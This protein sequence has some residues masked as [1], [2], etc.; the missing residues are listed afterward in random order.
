MRVLAAH[1]NDAA[2]S[3]ISAERLL[4]REPA[5]A[6][7]DDAAITTGSDAAKQAR[8]KPRRI[9]NRFW[10][11]LS[12]EPL[13]VSRYPNYSNADL[14]A[15]HLE[16]IW[17]R[18][19]SEGDQLV[20]AVPPSMDNTQLALFL[21]V[22]AEI[23]I[24]VAGLFD[25][26]VAATRREYRGAVPVH[27]DVSLHRVSVSRLGQSSQVVAERSEILDASGLVQLSDAWIRK[28]S[29]CFV[30][31]SRFDPLHTAETEQMLA[32]ALPDWLASASRSDSISMTVDYHGID[33]SAEIESLDLVSAAAPVY[34]R[35]AAQLRALLRA[36]EVPA[37][38]LSDRAARLPGLAELLT[39]R[40]GGEV[41]LLE[42]GAT[43]RGLLQRAK[44]SAGNGG[45]VSL[46]RALPW[47]QAAVDVEASAEEGSGERPTHILFGSVA[48]PITA[49]PLVLGS[50]ADGDDRTV[51]FGREMPGLSRRHCS[52][53]TNGGQCVVEDHSRY[54]TFLN[55][56]KIDGSVVLQ[57]GDILRLGTPGFELQLIR[58]EG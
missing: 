48:Y 18:V 44:V 1:L 36:D 34:Q 40:V 11:A 58:T 17:G 9:Q 51:E 20:V 15:R 4:Y 21:G 43:A 12:T 56:H 16:D 5:Y 22:A 14:V 42:P 25:A 24:P 55:G 57:S 47:D 3:V 7:L 33:H 46:M 54:G 10:D 27:I 30:N 32:D 45:A 19:S 49:E 35:I 8:L 23:G 37:I 28:I 39:A 2:I 29:D 50:Q 31:Q 38:Q 52:L 6:L 41:F 53:F 26:A 13:G